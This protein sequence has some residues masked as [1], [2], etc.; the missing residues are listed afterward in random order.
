MAITR[1]KNRHT[2]SKSCHKRNSEIIRHP[3]PSTTPNPVNAIDAGKTERTSIFIDS[4]RILH[5]TVERDTKTEVSS[6]SACQINKQRKIWRITGNRGGRSDWS[7]E[8]CS[9]RSTNT[10][11]DSYRQS[12][13]CW[14]QS[15]LFITLVLSCNQR[16]FLL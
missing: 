12:I 14:K 2:W 13:I 5:N 4:H 16:W 6:S 7:I 15:F 11:K 1:V 9:N 10:C 8:I 3:L